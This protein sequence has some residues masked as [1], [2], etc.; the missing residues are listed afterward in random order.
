V[1]HVGHELVLVL[2]GDL[3]VF[4]RFGKFASARLY[5]LK[6][7][8]VLYRY[9]CLVCKCL[10][11][12]DLFFSKR[13]NNRTTKSGSS[14]WRPLPSKEVLLG[15]SYGLVAS[16]SRNLKEILAEP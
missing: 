12:R 6:Q 7:P 1:A 14:R 11:E 16:R 5:L 10:Q 3:E 15:L 9:D 8:G 4:D 2:A 13:L